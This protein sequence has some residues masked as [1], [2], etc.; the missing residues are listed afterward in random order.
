LVEGVILGNAHGCVI[1]DCKSWRNGHAPAEAVAA[2]AAEEGIVGDAWTPDKRHGGYDSYGGS[3]NLWLRFQA[4]D[5]TGLGLHTTSPAEEKVGPMKNITLR[6][7]VLRGNG[8]GGSGNLDAS[9]LRGLLV[10]DCL[11]ASGN[12]GFSTWDD[13]SGNPEK[14]A[15]G[16]VFRRSTIYMPSDRFTIRL[17]SGGE[18]KMDSCIVAGKAPSVSASRLTM[19][20]ATRR[21]SVQEAQAWLDPVTLRSLLPGVGYQ[22]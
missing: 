14:G 22:G 21:G 2:V 19:D 11:L 16:V 17:E 4:W 18:V 20:A 9:N 7:C 13:A 10:E 8:S 3:D 5:N 15:K 12:G 1:E 6:G